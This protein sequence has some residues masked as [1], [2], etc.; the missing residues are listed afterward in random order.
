MG[1]LRKVQ[2]LRD[3]TT[4]TPT[5]SDSMSHREAHILLRDSAAPS[6]PSPTVISV[7]SVFLKG[8]ALHSPP[9]TDASP[10]GKQQLRGSQV[11]Q[12]AQGG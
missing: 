3:T 2:S 4:R 1:H 9:G 12:K 10:E 7:A 6:R 8:P 5:D 11:A